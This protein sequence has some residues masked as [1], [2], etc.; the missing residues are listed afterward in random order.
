[1]IFSIYEAGFSTFGNRF[2]VAGGFD[3][4]LHTYRGGNS[5]YIFEYIIEEDNFRRLPQELQAGMF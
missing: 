2:L 3:D 5:F 4:Y 1:M